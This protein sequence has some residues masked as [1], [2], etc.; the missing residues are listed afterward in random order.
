MSQS[1][2]RRS[3]YSQENL[4]AM[5]QPAKDKETLLLLHRP[6]WMR[7]MYTRFLQQE[8]YL[9]QCAKNPFEASLCLSRTSVDLV[10]LDLSIPEVHPV[11]WMQ[12]VRMEHGPIPFLL[13]S[14]HDI[15]QEYLETLD[16][17]TVGLFVQ[18]TPLYYLHDATN[19]ALRSLAPK[20]SYQKRLKKLQDKFHHTMKKE[21]HS[22]QMCFMTRCATQ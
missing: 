11:T 22:P 2:S 10:L 15:S 21:A 1:Y 6:G 5:F 8:G 7:R 20:P 12:E 18:G 9:V 16:M 4:S 19:R 3:A 17:G 13:L 14:P